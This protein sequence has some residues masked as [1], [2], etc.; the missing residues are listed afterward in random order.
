M[1][2][3]PC[4]WCKHNI[5]EHIPYYDTEFFFCPGQ[6]DEPPEIMDFYIP[7]TNLQYLEWIYNQKVSKEVTS[8]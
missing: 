7:M 3:R 1:K 5:E 8:K 4:K 6:H 2:K